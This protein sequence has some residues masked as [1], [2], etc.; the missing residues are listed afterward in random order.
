MMKVHMRMLVAILAVGPAILSA[1]DRP[2]S[3]PTARPIVPWTVLR[4]GLVDGS[5]DHRRQAVLAAGSIG[6]TPDAVAFIEEALRDKETIVRQTAAAV[7]GQL[8]APESI[9]CSKGG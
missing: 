7:L 6:A 1:Q 5:T 8:K 2:T 9:P 3:A 4:Q